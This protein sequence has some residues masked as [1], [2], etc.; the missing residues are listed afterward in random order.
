[1]NDETILKNIEPNNFLRD[2]F[3]HYTIAKLLS[4]FVPGRIF[5]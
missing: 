4:L 1:M 3:S 5:L 2:Y